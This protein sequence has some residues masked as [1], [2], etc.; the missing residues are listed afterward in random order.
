MLERLLAATEQL[1][2]GVA[3]LHAAGRLH[4]DIKPSNVLVAKTGRVVILDFGLVTV[5]ERAGRQDATSGAM[6]GTF[7]YMA[8]EQVW[9]GPITS[10]ADLYSVG[11][12][13]YES[14]TGHLPFEGDAARV[15]VAKA[16]SAPAPL[17]ERVPAVPE[18][19]DALVNALLQPD[20]ARRPDVQTI[21]TE[22]SA[23]RPERAALMERRTPIVT[24][25]P[26]VGR[27]V[28]LERLRAALA[29]MRRGCSVCVHVE[30]PSG[31][32]KTE[33][34]GSFLDD[35]ENDGQAWVLRGR[36]HAQESVPYKAFDA[37]IDGLT[38]GLL[39]RFADEAYAVVPRHAWALTRLFPVLGRVPAFAAWSERSEDVEPHEV[40]RRGFSALR[41]LFARI[42]DRHSLVL[43]ID[44][45][46]WA[47]LD[48]SMLLRELLRPPEPPALLLVLSYRDEP[49]NDLL[50][51]LR[52]G[53]ED[54]AQNADRV[55]VHPLDRDEA[56]TLASLLCPP[57]PQ[58]EQR[59]VE[60]VSESAGSP[61]LIGE[62]ARHLAAGLSATGE[63]LG[64]PTRLTD[65]ITERVG[66]LPPPA[67]RLLELIVIAGQPIDR[68]IALHAAGLGERG[69]PLLTMLGHACLVRT[70]TVQG[71]AALEAYHDRIGETLAATLSTRDQQ[72]RHG[73]LADAL[74]TRP[75]PDPEAVFRH[76]L[77]SGRNE[78]AADWAV[79]AADRAAGAL[80]FLR[81]AELY[82]RALE[83]KSW[84]D[85]RTAVLQTS[86][87]DALVAAGRSA[88]AAPMYAAAATKSTGSSGLDLRRRAAEQFLV[89]GHI[90]EGIVELRALFA[91][92][93]LPYPTSPSGASLGLVR[94][95]LQLWLRGTSFVARSESAVERGDLLRIDA[96]NSAAKGLVQVDP[97]RGTYF[98]ALAL[99]L[100]LRAGEPRRIGRDLCLG[101]SALVVGGGRLARWGM[102]M[103][104]LVCR[105]AEETR[106]PY[107][108][109][110]SAITLG[111]VSILDGRW[112]DVVRL[113]DQ[114][115]GVL[116]DQCRGVTWERDIGRMAVIRALEEL[117]DVPEVRRRAESLKEE[118][119]EIGDLYA[120]LTARQ[121]TAFWR[122]AEDDFAR[123]RAE[124]RD[125]LAL[126]S[127]A[128][129]HLQ[130]F[131][132]LRLE[133]YCDIYE[134]NPEAAWA[135]VAEAW[136]LLRRSNLLRHPVVRVD[137]NLLRARVALAAAAGEPAHRLRTATSC[138]RRLSRERRSDARAHGALIR[139]GIASARGDNITYAL[140]SLA[141]AAQQ[142]ERTGV[143]LCA[144]YA[145][146]R[147][148]ELLGGTEGAS[149]MLEAEAVMTS[150]TI[151][152]PA[153]WLAVHAPGFDRVEP[154]RH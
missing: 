112:Q 50:C 22:L 17:R 90:D 87:A 154:R 134:D 130:H 40:R 144:A 64:G 1:V 122:L 16:K 9:G 29:R 111:V 51:S 133:S 77:G 79:R 108:I 123:A 138:A 43:W 128:G 28:E 12:M 76:C 65:A 101:A 110:I 3:A 54:L 27:S 96:C 149:R 152:N 131:Y 52:E 6:V 85:P 127:H 89:S 4:R 41:E 125:A 100:A 99:L 67:R 129:Y 141:E 140:T 69:R 153:R 56:N 113:C 83:L 62:L 34:V 80:A 38:R 18:R 147:Y 5:L 7:S 109:G 88:A 105:M 36:C 72:A 139:A 46:Q 136:P 81:A 63:G 93:R 2:L 103:L 121:Y 55:L 35:V 116:R 124:G 126:W 47:D 145:R 102:E 13:L 49:D 21:L 30:G 148:G 151:R 15:M 42:A 66:Q 44:D 132:A 119:E 86:L 142:F 39:S 73:A 97:I 92:L 150:R 31:I 146:R 137:A 82:R 135:R 91:D 68:S 10:A 57:H 19:I 118:A 115:G 25:A 94:R 45:V 32:G 26:F 14:V 75:S 23:L 107:L 33:L 70:T 106:D 78:E 59:I 117:G 48:S 95:L 120:Q 11:V 53:V 20:H 98:S 84:E 8:P 61:F 37:L 71:H 104:Q 143:L 60:I 74:Q 24:E 114:G 58:R